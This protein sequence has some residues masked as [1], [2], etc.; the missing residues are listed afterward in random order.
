[1]RADENYK[2]NPVTLRNVEA[3]DDF[4]LPDERGMYIFC[5][6]HVFV[7]YINTRLKWQ[8]PKL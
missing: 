7:S 2:E 5:I 6:I 4:S 3:L 8:N 1:M